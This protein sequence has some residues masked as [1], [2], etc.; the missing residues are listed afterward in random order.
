MDYKHQSQKI[1][2]QTAK[3]NRFIYILKEKMRNKKEHMEEKKTWWYDHIYCAV[4]FIYTDFIHL[5]Y[6]KEIN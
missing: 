1:L 2:M 6:R 5:I 3:N 4:A